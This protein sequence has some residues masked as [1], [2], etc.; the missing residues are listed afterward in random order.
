M[1]VQEIDDLLA[2]HFREANA[3]LVDKAPST[4]NRGEGTEKSFFLMKIDLVGSTPLL[5]NRRQS[6]YLKLA[7][8]FLS[9]I[10]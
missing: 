9:T 5:W 8:T 6:T 4:L 10:D 1:K 7:H 2:R 3:D